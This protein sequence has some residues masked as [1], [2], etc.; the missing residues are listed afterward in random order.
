[1]RVISNNTRLLSR[2]RH[3]GGCDQRLVVMGEVSQWNEEYMDF[4]EFASDLP[5]DRLVFNSAEEN[6]E[7]LQRFGVEQRVRQVGRGHFRAEMAVCITPHADLYADRFST[8]NTFTLSAPAG[9][10]A[11]LVFPSE[12]AD[13]LAEGENVANEKL[14][15]MSAG[16]TIDIRTSSNSGSEAIVI[17]EDRFLAAREALCPGVGAP[18][19]FTALAGDTA[20]L[21]ALRLAVLDAM[22]DPPARGAQL[23]VQQLVESIIM[24]TVDA[25]PTKPSHRIRAA[26]RRFAVA[27]RACEYIDANYRHAIRSEDLCR[28]TGAGIRTLQRCFREHCGVTITD[29]LKSLRFQAAWRELVAAHPE[30]DSVTQ[31]A[32]KHGFSHLGRFSVEFRHRFGDSPKQVLAKRPGQKH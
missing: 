1:M 5:A 31:I 3:P 32:L 19:G 7:T 25:S 23:P 4:N 30:E 20:A 12:K 14:A 15:L 24:W 13:L 18:E 27:K 9:R 2:L 21:K 16:T 8:A 17:P 10:I 11:L 29:Y 28:V 6:E 22:A 26:D